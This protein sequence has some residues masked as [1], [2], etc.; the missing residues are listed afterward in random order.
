MIRTCRWIVSLVILGLFGAAPVAATS[1]FP[2]RITLERHEL[3]RL[4]QGT[5]RYAGIIRVYDAALYA[6]L[7]QGTADILDQRV[8]KR[9]EIVYLRKLEGKVLEQAALH[10][11]ERQHGGAALERWQSEIDSL[12]AA[13]RDVVPG[14]RFALAQTPERGLWLEFNGREVARVEAQAFAAV[15]FGI[16]LGERPL[17][18]SLRDAL[19]SA[20]PTRSTDLQRWSTP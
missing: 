9:L 17:S 14:D 13:Y 6:A 8:P 12:H 3:Q 18:D 5:A 10:T 16:W 1:S 11:L 2:E 7:P 4:G 19:L 20:Y 15:Y